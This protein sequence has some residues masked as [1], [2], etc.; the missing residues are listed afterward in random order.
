MIQSIRVLDGMGEG[1]RCVLIG[2]GMSVNDFDWSIVTKDMVTIAINEAIPEALGYVDYL[3]YRDNAFLRILKTIPRHKYGQLIGFSMS[4]CA[5]VLP[6][7]VYTAN[8]FADLG[9]DILQSD[10]T[11]LKALVFAKR[12]MRF[13]EIYL[14]G[15]DFQTR[16]VD[17]KERSHFYGDFIGDG[18][19][20]THEGYFNDHIARLGSMIE[21]FQRFPDT[22]GIWQCYADSQLKQFPFGLPNTNG[23]KT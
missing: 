15:F 18:M 6:N 12:L 4:Q 20:Y 2:G 7:F 11:G 10:N 13:D 22:S 3:I 9:I 19:K 14:I 23:G 17:G 16:H 5:E 8:D 21:E 1:R